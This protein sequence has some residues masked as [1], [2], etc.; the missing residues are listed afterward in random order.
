M[1]LLIGL[2]EA[3][4][5][6]NLGPLV[7][8][9]TVW[10]VPGDPRGF[11]L[12]ATSGGAVSRT[13]DPAGR[14][15]HVADSKSVH[16]SSAGIVAIERSA[17]A[18]L[19]LAGRNADSLFGLWD[20]LT[21]CSD[22]AGCGE[23]WFDG[24]DLRLPVSGQPQEDQPSDAVERW[25]AA[26]AAANCRLVAVA[27]EIVPA[28]RFNGAVGRSGSK[29]RLLSET[30]LALLRRVWDPAETSALVLCD[31]HGGRDRYGDLL[32]DTFPDHLPLGLEESRGMSRYRLGKGEV[33]FQVRSE[34]HLPVAAASIVAKYMREAAMA[35]FNRFW[36]ARCPG[37]RPTAGYPNDA[38]RFLAEI[39][40]HAASLGLDRSVFWRCR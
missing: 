39:E 24:E 6:P 27:C 7:V 30:T 19:R 40:A 22:R 35:A 16:S 34:E 1:P 10:D 4:Y 11:D 2:D 31:K 38:K 13:H 17:T 33:R 21:G 15:V 23:P 14:T 36:L 5:G 32:A 8:A 18:I 26:C 9:T 29:G 25:S 3:G 37:L 20:G 28:L 12:F